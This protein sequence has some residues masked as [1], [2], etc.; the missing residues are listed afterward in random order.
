MRIGL[1]SGEYPPMQGGV[2]DFSR[3]LAIALAQLGHEVHVVTCVGCE[4]KNRAIPH[5]QH[6]SHLTV[7]PTIPNWGWRLYGRVMSLAR[8]LNLDVLNVQY[9][10]AAYDLHPAI[11]FLP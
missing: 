1:I 10:A 2:G 8:R 9:Q 5:K 4:A 7:H 6:I 11:N 3:E